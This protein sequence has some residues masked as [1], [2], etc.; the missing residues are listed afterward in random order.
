MV[1]VKGIHRTIGT[2]IDIALAIIVVLLL[3]T[4]IKIFLVVKTFD[5][6]LFDIDVDT[7][8]ILAVAIVLSWLGMKFVSLALMMIIA[9]LSMVN[10][11]NINQAMGIWGT[12][13]VM[14]AFVGFLFYLSVEPAVIEARPYYKRVINNGMRKMKEDVGELGDVVKENHVKQNTEER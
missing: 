5:F 11:V 8:I 12:V 4:F 13:F 3:S 10:V 2:K 14:C 9:V 1:R 7:R 6:I